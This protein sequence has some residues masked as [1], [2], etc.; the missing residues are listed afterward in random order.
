MESS[1]DVFNCRDCSKAHVPR[2]RRS[3]KTLL[4]DKKKNHKKKILKIVP[5]IDQFYLL[6]Y[7]EGVWFIF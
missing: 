5:I 6:I 7:L 1:E 3:L 2:L 4:N